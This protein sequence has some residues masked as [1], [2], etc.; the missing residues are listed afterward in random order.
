MYT[1][2]TMQNHDKTISSNKPQKGVRSGSKGSHKCCNCALDYMGISRCMDVG[3]IIDFQSHAS[4]IQT[5]C[6]RDINVIC[7]SKIIL[8]GK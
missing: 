3:E 8:C 5:K 6:R 4:T 7:L 1:T 2:N